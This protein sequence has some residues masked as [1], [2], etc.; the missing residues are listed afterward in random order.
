MQERLAEKGRKSSHERKIRKYSKTEKL[1]TKLQMEKKMEENTKSRTILAVL[2]GSSTSISSSQRN[3]KT[4]IIYLKQKDNSPVS[5]ILPN[6]VLSF[7]F[8]VLL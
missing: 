7:C 3:K 5:S 6:I 1:Q 4:R 2:D 8:K